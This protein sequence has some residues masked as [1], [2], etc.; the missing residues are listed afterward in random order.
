[1]NSEATDTGYW[2]RA[3]E[4][5]SRFW[6]AP[7]R[8]LALH[9][10]RFLVGFAV[11]G[12]YIPL[13]SHVEDFFGLKGWFDQQAF[14]DAATFPNGAPVS[15]G[16]SVLYLAGTNSVALH[17]IYWAIMASVA[18]FTAGVAPRITSILTWIGVAS[19]S[20]NPIIDVDANALLSFLTFYLMIGYLLP[21]APSFG[22]QRWFGPMTVWPIALSSQSSSWTNRLPMRLIQIHFAL[23][24]VASGFHKLQFG[25]WWAG[26]A[27][28]YSLHPADATNVAAVRSQIT[29]PH[30]YL[31]GISI[32][33]Y[34][35]LIWQITFPTFAW[36]PSWR[37]L[38][39]VGGVVG[40]LGSW[41]VTKEPDFGLAFFAGCACYVESTEWESWRKRLGPARAEVDTSWMQ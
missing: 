3:A 7:A 17:A 11:L 15:F 20:A 1:M 12:S 40:L 25:D 26:V 19:L 24:V 37:W 16:W 35:I 18:L 33:A 6:F 41:I 34:V 31:R 13:A 27:W 14:A 2:R 4:G 8:P 38:L 21:T 30:M 32:A 28:W 9:V 10:A 39:I 36:R 23:A 29:N 5:W 22:L